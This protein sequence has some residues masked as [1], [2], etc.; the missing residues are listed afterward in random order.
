MN[1]ETSLAPARTRWAHVDFTPQY[2][3]DETIVSLEIT[4]DWDKYT[5]NSLTG[6]HE[7]SLEARNDY[8][9]TENSGALWPLTTTYQRGPD[10]P[11]TVNFLQTYNIEAGDQLSNA[12]EI[13]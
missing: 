11:A 6:Y 5:L 12:I 9:M 8:D 13:F 3:T 7:A 2:E 10:G 4:H 1:L